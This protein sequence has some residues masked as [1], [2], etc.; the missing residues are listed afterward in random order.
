MVTWLQGRNKMAGG[1]GRGKGAQGIQEAES[2]VVPWIGIPLPG[3]HW[4]LI[5]KCV[6]SPLPSDSSPTRPR[7]PIIHLIA[8]LINR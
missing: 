3:Q 5:S 8:E 1:H 2:K 7:L 4:P 6:S